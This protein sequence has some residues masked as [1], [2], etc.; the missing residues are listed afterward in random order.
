[1]IFLRKIV[2]VAAMALLPCVTQGRSAGRG[3]CWDERSLAF[4][5]AHAEQIA[6]GISWVYN[7]G[8]D[9]AN[10]DLFGGQS[11]L[12]FA[13]M[14]WNGAFSESRIR[15][16]L[17]NHPETEYLLGF[18]EPNFADQA[19]MTPEEAARLWPVLEKIASDFNV[20]LVAPALNFSASQVGGRV[21]NPYEWYDE[22]FRIYPDARV[23]LLA[24]HCYMNW[25]SANTWLATEYFYSDLY[26]PRKDCYGRY[27]NLV[28][29]LDGY[30]AAN[31]HFP[32][33][34]LTEFCSW[35]N[36]GTIKNVDFQID[37]MTQKVQMLELS[38]L[39]EG[40]AWFMGNAAGGAASYPYMSLFQSNTAQSALSELGKV[41][42]HMSSF[43]RTRYYAP[44]EVIEA[45]DYVNATTDD[46]QIRVRS[47]SES[48]SSLPL[49]I[50]IPAGGYPDYQI[51][52][53]TT[54]EYKFTFHVCAGNPTQLILYIDNKKDKTVAIGANPGV[55]QDVELVTELSEGKHTIMLYNAG[56]EPVLMNSFVFSTEGGVGLT[57]ADTAAPCYYTLQGICLGE[58]S[59]ADLPKGVYIA[60]YNDNKSKTIIK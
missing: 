57:E 21:W 24:M 38:D 41:Y 23:D 56:A 19:K 25:Y 53:S 60:R 36:D 29:F 39:V 3:I 30:K 50:E 35:E 51:E 16:W 40:Y 27:P 32:K 22:F 45:K 52:A 47:N 15:A 54:D 42:V 28:R 5:A 58:V 33:M 9:A 12:S 1:M 2:M 7:W 8:P 20:R 26:N 49:Q 55:W 6:P 48:F 43:D 44:N 4:S 17:G 11:T 31:G 13:P 18:N 10:A 37:Q 46:R 34:M 14:A 59:Y